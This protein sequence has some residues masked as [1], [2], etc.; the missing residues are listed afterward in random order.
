MARP[1]LVM[2]PIKGLSMQII[3][4][5]MYRFRSNNIKV[6]S[7]LHIFEDVMFM[8][9]RLTR[10]TGIIINLRKGKFLRK[11]SLYEEYSKLGFIEAVHQWE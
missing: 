2:A 9:E 8:L 5:V 11:H 7:Y 1:S 3:N 10:K 6:S 4:Q